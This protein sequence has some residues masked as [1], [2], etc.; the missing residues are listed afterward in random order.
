MTT[1]S[2]RVQPVHPPAAY[3]GG[4]KKLAERLCARIEAVRHRTYAE[5]FIGMGGVFL[6]RRL[7]PP[8]EVINDISGDVATFWRVLQHHY[9]ALMGEL[10]YKLTSRDE[11]QRLLA[12]P[13][14]RL[15]DLQRAA[16]FLYVQRLAF[17][18]KVAGRNF[19]VSPGLPGRFDVTRIGAILDEVHQRLS[20]VII[21][22]L[23]YAD[24]IARY[25]TPETLFFL[26]PPYFGSE[27]DYGAGVFGP[28]DFARLAG[29][30]AG[31]AGRFILTVNDCPEMRACFGGFEIHAEALTYSVMGGAPLDVT[32]II[33]TSPG[34]PPP[35]PAAQGSL[36]ID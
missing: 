11:F 28:E 26:D 3:I 33:V 4:K 27:A 2:R 25:D 14:E 32:E 23:P 16:R 19:G 12:L 35:L 8:C 10:R 20:G 24:L 7:A 21:E 34:L 9:E 6:R 22:R 36:M 1:Q 5:P 18:G 15:T 13:P 17:G 31:I 29:Q 30:L